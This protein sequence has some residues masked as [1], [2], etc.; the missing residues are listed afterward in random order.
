MSMPISEQEEQLHDDGD[1]VIQPLENMASPADYVT[2]PKNVKLQVSDD[3][4][5]DDLIPYDCVPHSREVPYY[6]REAISGTFCLMYN[7][8]SCS[9]CLLSYILNESW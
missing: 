1:H 8:T 4:D 3:D 6:L 9:I 7:N 5:D 2:E